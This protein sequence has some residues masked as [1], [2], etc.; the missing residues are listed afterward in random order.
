MIA[1]GAC[2]QEE[3]HSTDANEK[4]MF[5]QME[6]ARYSHPLGV[7]SFQNNLSIFTVHLIAYL[8]TYKNKILT[9]EH[10]KRLKQQEGKLFQRYASLQL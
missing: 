7:S 3:N 8:L 4:K 1:Q 5:T 10:D 2:C 6:I 9:V